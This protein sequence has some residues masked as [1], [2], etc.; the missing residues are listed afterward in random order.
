MLKTKPNIPPI[1]VIIIGIISIST[2]SIFIRFAQ[3]ESS[4]IVIAAYR[5]FITSLIIIPIF[6]VKKK[7]EIKNLSKNDFLLAILSGFFLALHFA[8]WITSL[9][10]TTIASS[11]VL[12]CTNP[13][14]VALLSPIAIKEK[15]SKQVIIGLLFSL[16][17]TVIIS[18]SGICKFNGTLTCPPI[19]E[20][21][22][23]KT[24]LGNFLALFGAWMAAGYI[25]IGRKLRLKTST[26]TYSTLVY[27]ISAIFLVIFVFISGQ[28]FIGFSSQTYFYLLLLAIIPQLI[29]H[30]SFNWALGYLSATFIAITILGEPIGAMILGYIVFSEKP[31]PLN[32]IGA[33]LI[34][35]G[36]LIAFITKKQIQETTGD[37]NAN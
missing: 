26:L 14:W 21:L 5:L 9:E 29:G 23:T 34:L 17:G 28:K 20:I 16:L 11:V 13:L 22:N 12:V 2:A 24:L 27:S 35:I 10:Y 30:T 8:A 19:N 37:K 36:I 31:S 25:L 6:L 18:I 33:I 7:S 1:I 4:S 32:L 15:V 3:Q